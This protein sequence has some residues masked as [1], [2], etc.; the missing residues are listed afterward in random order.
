MKS[1]KEVSVLSGVSVRTLHYYDEI[2][3]LKPSK[4]TDAGYRYYDGKALSKLQKILLL[5]ELKFSLKDIKTFVENEGADRTEALR[6]QIKLLEMQRE[7]IDGIISLARDIIEKGDGTV[8]FTVFDTKEMDSFAK[9][10]KERWGSTEAYKEYGKKAKTT[11]AENAGEGLMKLFGEIGKIKDV[12]A[13]SKEALDAAKRV[14]A[15]ITEHFYSC[16]PEILRSLGEMYVAD[17]RFR[18][19]IDKEGGAGTAEFISRA[20]KEYTK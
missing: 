20:I 8:D 14:Q 12:P 10:I 19:N 2:G 18:N 15:Y 6:E 9:E 13:D 4:V 3:L 17:E 16:S 5:K 11:D 7:H 1:V